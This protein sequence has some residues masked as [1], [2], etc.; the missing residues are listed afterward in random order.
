[1]IAQNT[2][3]QKA[4][5]PKPKDKRKF[6]EGASGFMHT[7]V[8]VRRLMLMAPR[9]RPRRRPR[10][11]RVP[12]PCTSVPMRKR[13]DIVFAI[14]TSPHILQTLAIWWRWGWLYVLCGIMHNARIVYARIAPIVYTTRSALLAAERP[15]NGSLLEHAA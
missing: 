7:P 10:D 4:N 15:A 2:R 13:R 5:E 6:A 3:A 11:V 12:A 8:D 9:P 1:V 14:A